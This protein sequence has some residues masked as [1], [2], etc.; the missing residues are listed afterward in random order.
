MDYEDWLRGG[1]PDRP[2]WSQ[3]FCRMNGELRLCPKTAQ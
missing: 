3:I 2:E 1:M